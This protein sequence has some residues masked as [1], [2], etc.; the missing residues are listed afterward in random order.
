MAATDTAST[1][2]SSAAL[3]SSRLALSITEAA[4]AVGLSKSSV[5]EL[6]ADRKIVARKAGRRSL[7]DAASLRAWLSSLPQ[8]PERRA[9]A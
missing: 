1:P 7:V 4:Q 3:D 6:I 2:T 8:L 5:Y 9:A